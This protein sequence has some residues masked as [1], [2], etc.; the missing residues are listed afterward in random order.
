MSLGH[1]AFPLFQHRKEAEREND[2]STDNAR[3]CLSQV[4][5]SEPH[6]DPSF[7]LG[8]VLSGEQVY[9]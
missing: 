8:A 4:G 9:P 1:R 7:V 3:K 2:S 6:P 5:S